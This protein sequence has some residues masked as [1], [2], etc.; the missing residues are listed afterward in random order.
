[1]SAISEKQS[2]PQLQEQIEKFISTWGA[3]GSAWGINRTLSQIHAL[4]L[5]TPHPMTTEEIME[6]LSISRGNANTNLRELVRWGLARV[7][8]IRGQRKDFFE[9]EK[10]VWK[11]FCAVTRGRKQ[12]EID[13][14]LDVLKETSQATA[15]DMTPEGKEF[16]RITTELASFVGTAGALMDRVARS[17]KSK[18]LPLLLK[19][20]P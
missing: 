10:D 4:L 11:I 13:P 8:A 3:M 18:V 20:I 5:A 7:I 17:E 15:S 19:L 14:A 16:H 2:N 9:A 12:Q 1:M 6:A